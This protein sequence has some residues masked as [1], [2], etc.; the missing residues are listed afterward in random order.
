MENEECVTCGKN[1]DAAESFVV[2]PCPG[3][4]EAVARCRRCKKLR[5]AYECGSCG[6]RGP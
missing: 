6:F 5:N 3:C 4:G 1:L 2:I